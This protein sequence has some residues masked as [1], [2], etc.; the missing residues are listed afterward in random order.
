MRS[1][2]FIDFKAKGDHYDDLIWPPAQ[3]EAREGTQRF[4][5]PAR[6]FWVSRSVSFRKTPS[7]NVKISSNRE[8]TTSLGKL[9]QQLVIL[10]VKNLHLISGLKISSFS[11]Q[12]RSIIIPSSARPMTPLIRHL[13]PI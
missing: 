8:P 9:F 7:V 3:H 11:L 2:W 6:N 13:P 1:V 12:P 5:H 10:T 4:L